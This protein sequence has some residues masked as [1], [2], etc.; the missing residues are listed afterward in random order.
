MHHT[1]YS[2]SLCKAKHKTTK[3][4]ATNA[5]SSNFTQNSRTNLW[6]PVVVALLVL[7]A[8]VQ[9]DPANAEPIMAMVGYVTL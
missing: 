1:D 8:I 7:L 6:Q 4:S 9:M 3:N 2:I 5:T